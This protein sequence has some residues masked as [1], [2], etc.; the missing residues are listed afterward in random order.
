[1]AIKGGD[2]ILEKQNWST[3]FFGLCAFLF[4]CYGA[5]IYQEFVSRR[6]YIVY[7]AKFRDFERA[8]VEDELAAFRA[9]YDQEEAKLAATPA[10]DSESELRNRLAEAMAKQKSAEYK[11]LKKEHWDA[12]V[13]HGFNKSERAKVKSTQDAQFYQWK[14]AVHH[15][16]ESEVPPKQDLYWKLEE[17][18]A[19]W[20]AKVDASQATLDAVAAKMALID[21]EVKEAQK[22]LDARR[23]PV[24]K[25]EERLEK[26]ADRS[27]RNIDQIVN[28]KLGIGGAYT[29]G[30]VDR[31]RSCHVAIDRPGF[32]Q[33]SFASIK[34][35]GPV[36]P[37]K[38]Y[39]KVFS[40][41]P[42]IDPLFTKHPIETYGCTVCHQGQ[43]RATRIKTPLGKSPDAFVFA[44]EKD[45]AHGTM[46]LWEYPL[47]RWVDVQSSCQKCHN[48]QRFVD[49]APVYERGKDLFLRKGC[50][51]CH[52]VK[53]YEPVGRVGPDLM[54]VAA[55]L[56]P[57]W[58]V[59]WI[60]NPKAF[61]PE[62]RMPAF[63]FDEF[64][65][66]AADPAGN[67]ANVKPERQQE[68][69]TQ[70]AAYLWQSSA[71]AKAMPFGRFPGGGDAAA[72][73]RIVDT[74]GC[75]ACHSIEGKGGND[76]PPLHKAGAKLASADWIWNWIRQPRW[77]SSTTVM[78][79]FR[80]S[81]EEAR[82]VTAYLWA[83]G[84]KERPA[85]DPE[86]VKRLAD[87]AAAKAGSTLIAQW[88]CAACHV[89]QD[90]ENDGRIGPELTLFAEK[91][92]FELGFG[93]SKVAHN[94][95]AWTRGKLENP[96]QYVDVRSAGRMPWF[97]LKPDEIDA[98]LVYLKGQKEFRV[99]PEFQKSFTG[100]NAAIERG[101]QLVTQYNCVGCHLIE[102]RGGEILAIN[103]DR[104]L[105]PP[106]LNMEG[107]K[108]QSDYLLAFLENP[109]PIRPWLKIRMPTFP[110]TAQE[111]ADIVA[112]FRAVDAVDSAYDEIHLSSADLA[113][114]EQGRKLFDQFKCQSCHIFR[115]V[116]SASA[117]DDK[118]APDLGNVHRRFRPDGVEAW[119]E[120]PQK[121]MPG[122]NMP[123][124]FYDYDVKSGHL[125]KLDPA[126]DEQI[127]AIRAFLFSLGTSRQ[128]SMR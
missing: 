11:A 42:K 122:T 19:A 12:Y 93:D 84:A 120:A 81:D 54:R 48:V 74:V 86:L 66:G 78:P 63:A 60:A 7:Q 88:G 28:D 30:T 79:S 8:K 97:G 99:S 91:K 105:R 82:H 43:G 45:Q 70:I 125:E 83:A 4:L 47:L 41:H 55:K 87:P 101:R 96:R 113:R 98:L 94:W 37:Y 5:S 124:F 92:P 33:D 106:N 6:T 75:L 116:R 35:D 90:H 121:V 119:L 64:A 20:T 17:E 62:T 15:G 114:V 104:S 34:A 56:S 109:T 14:N 69:A 24:A 44:A 38:E 39:D 102:G 32:E 18:I 1:M 61:Y 49:G 58:L 77:H 3:W 10:V 26:I 13:D 16:E 46:H 31:C 115:G 117:T 9:K 118:V 65:P 110:L 22:A 68:A 21:D 50:Q 57:E 103:K 51:G 111:R 29:F 40:T 108:I 112:Y 95:D 85:A 52:L 80:L 72:G 67:V 100:R 59:R 71:D 2:P 27:I 36:A 107:L 123:G 25:F 76:A 126:A 23:E 128:L 73:R 89:I 53:G 127:D